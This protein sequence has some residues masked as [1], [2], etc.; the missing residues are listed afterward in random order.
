MYNRDLQTAVF[1]EINLGGEIRAVPQIDK[2]LIEAA[3]LGFKHAVIPKLSM[4]GLHKPAAI[5]VVAVEKADE[6]LDKLL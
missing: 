3:K 4:K 5:E 6:A 2:R 1:G